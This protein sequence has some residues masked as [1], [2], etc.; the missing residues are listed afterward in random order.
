ME[1]NSS[2][3]SKA[4]W[5]PAIFGDHMVLQQAQTL[6]VWG[7]ATAGVT[8]TVT[9]GD[10]Q[11]E[12]IA[13]ADGKWRVDFAPIQS[14]REG[15]ELQVVA[16]DHKLSFTDVLV[17]EVWLASGQSNMFMGITKMKNGEEDV[18]KANY[19]MLRLFIVE[20]QGGFE[21]QEEVKGKWV[22][23]SPETI[24]GQ[25]D[26]SFSAVGFYFARALMQEKQV[27][28]GMIASSVG[29]TRIH[30]WSSLESLEK[31]TDPNS[32][33]YQQTQ[34]FKYKRDNF[35]QRKEEYD[36][37]IKPAYDAAL[38]EWSESE[39]D[40]PEEPLDPAREFGFQTD[41]FNGMIHPI[42]PYAIKGALWY[43]GESNCYQK[44]NT[45]YA[46]LLPNMICDWRNRWGQGDFPFLYV[47]IPNFKIDNPQN[48]VSWP[49][50]RES[51]RLALSVPNTA[52]VV[53]IDVGDPDDLHPTVKKP[54]AD[55]LYLAAKQVAYGEDVVGECPLVGQAVLEAGKVVL[56]FT[57]M[58]GGLVT[59]EMDDEFNFSESEGQ[60]V[61]FELAGKDGVFVAAQAKIEGD[62]VVV[63]SDTLT[64]PTAIR[65]AWRQ[66]PEPAVNL[67][68]KAGLPAS[69]FR[70]ELDK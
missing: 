47:Q 31:I 65:Y 69:P 46:Q 49:M 57:G 14:N 66:S 64:K 70:L 3:L 26:R 1:F 23:C 13:D 30:C 18:A 12:T 54:I 24:I 39:D 67:Y 53:S 22:V 60:P 44:S 55:R 45:E 32:D 6:P 34:S 62:T 20:Q 17:G 27:P 11:M 25:N 36:T 42:I 8:V 56:S 2:H 9:L 63:W 33:T 61:N 5:L 51:Q 29:G 21:K 37:N 48:G 16:G 4:L 68:N 38:K 52:M 19:P 10:Q 7:R 58:G 15:V 35:D 50:L 40:P 41:L 59:G 28:V 43:Q